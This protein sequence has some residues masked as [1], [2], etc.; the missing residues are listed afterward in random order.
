MLK[1]SWKKQLLYTVME[2]IGLILELVGGFAA[3]I[4]GRIGLFLL[5]VAGALLWG[6]GIFLDDRMYRCPH[7]GHYLKE[8]NHRGFP[9]NHVFEHCPGCGW[10]VQIEQ[11]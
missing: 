11:E 6:A 4:S 1:I 7:C 10:L 3:V 2:V 5:F 9:S 8:R